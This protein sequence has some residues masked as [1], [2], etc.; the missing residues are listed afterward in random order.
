MRSLPLLR[1]SGGS[2]N[3]V[4]WKGKRLQII[5][6]LPRLRGS[7]LD[8]AVPGSGAGQASRREASAARPSRHAMTLL[9]S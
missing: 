3:M 1:F 9:F 4:N 7:G 5:A 2:R 6:R 8:L